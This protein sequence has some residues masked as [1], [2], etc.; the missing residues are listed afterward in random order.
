MD[1]NSMCDGGIKIVA[2]SRN[3]AQ[4]AVRKEDGVIASTARWRVLAGQLS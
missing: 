4:K 3:N 2:E 1:K